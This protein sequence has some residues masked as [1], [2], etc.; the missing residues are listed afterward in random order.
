MSDG[1]RIAPL[2]DD[3]LPEGLPRWNIFRTLQ[4]HPD[5]H[6]KW[7][8]F[9]GYLLGGGELPPRD[10]ELMILRVA[11]RCGSSYE[12]GQHVRSALASD[13]TREEIDRVPA[14][15]DAGGWS[16]HDATLLR[17]ADELHDTSTLSDATWAALAERYDERQLIEATMLVGQYHMVAFALN[18]FGVELDEGLEPLPQ[19]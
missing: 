6:R 11:V 4:R 17:A 19:P 3:E 12:W 5:L 16:A 9:G 2:G 14:G 13:V 8:R 7:L 1:P 18:A 10:R 15:P